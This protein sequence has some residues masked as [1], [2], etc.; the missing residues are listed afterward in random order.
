MKRNELSFR[1]EAFNRKKHDRSGF[2]CGVSILDDYLKKRM[3]QD[4]RR[5]VTAPFV[6][7]LE[8]TYKIIGF[9]TLSAVSIDLGTLPEDTVRKLP[10]YPELPATIIGRLAVDRRWRNRGV[11]EYLLMDALYRSWRQSHKIGAAAV[12][13]DAKD[14]NARKFYE[15][16]DFKSFPD[17]PDKLF[18]AMKTAAKLFR[19]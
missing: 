1:V 16:Y 4:A 14:D 10:Y 2:S 17:Q 9:Y 18:L 11:G 12:I 5:Y 8:N 3:G 15:R 6:L 7:C 13:V 19:D